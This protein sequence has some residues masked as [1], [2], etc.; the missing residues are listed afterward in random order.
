MRKFGETALPSVTSFCVGVPTVTQGEIVPGGATNGAAPRGR[1]GVGELAQRVTRVW[2]LSVR[3]DAESP[4]VEGPR[5]LPANVAAY[6][7]HRKV[8]G[9]PRRP[10]HYSHSIVGA[11][12]PDQFARTF[13]CNRVASKAWAAAR[14][15]QFPRGFPNMSQV[16]AVGGTRPR[17]VALTDS[18][19][20]RFVFST[21]IGRPKQRTVLEHRGVI[22][23]QRVPPDNEP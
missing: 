3:R 17:P 16:D 20:Y 9:Q 1:L 18:R 8:K 7:D 21:L 22:P 12:L 19:T 11:P 23:A 13:I 2:K 14:G 15:N 4:H 6:L 10:S 5:F